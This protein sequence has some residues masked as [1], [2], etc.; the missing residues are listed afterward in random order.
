MFSYWDGA[1][2]DG[3][4]RSRSCLLPV[5]RNTDVFEVLAYWSPPARQWEAKP[6][7]NRPGLLT[8]QHEELPV[9]GC[10]SY[11]ECM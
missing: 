9:L 4:G 7:A 6:K 3:A 11:P 10:T 5:D 8:L 2:P 1:S